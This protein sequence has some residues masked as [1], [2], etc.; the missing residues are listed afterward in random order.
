MRR[1]NKKA[2]PR[3][4]KD[5]RTTPGARYQAFDFLVDALLDEQGFVCAY[6]ERR[7]PHRDAPGEE[8]HRIEHLSSQMKARKERDN[9][10]LD[11]ANMVI[12]C[13]GNVANS[14]DHYHCD[15]AKGNKALMISPLSASMM[16]TIRF[17]P[18]GRIIS[19]DKELNVE[20]GENGLN[21]NDDFLVRS[22]QETWATVVERLNNIGWTKKHVCSLLDAW[23]GRHPFSYKG[24]THQ[25][26]FPFFSMICFMLRKKLASGI[27]R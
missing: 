21:L 5:Y 10:D 2:E 20:L 8:D 14:K 11:Y 1:I 9:S 12:C 17:T 23:E 16:S 18:S 7:I 13:P 4:W 15:K 25:A 24:A 3:A 6:C 27:L 26:H 19:T 22:R